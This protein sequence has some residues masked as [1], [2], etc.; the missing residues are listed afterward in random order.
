[1]L[2]IFALQYNV[3]E[4]NIKTPGL[5]KTIRMTTT[6][7]MIIIMIIIIIQFMIIDVPTQQS[8]D[9]SQKQHIT[10][11]AHHTNLNNKGRLTGHIWN[12]QSNKA[13]RMI[14]SLTAKQYIIKLTVTRL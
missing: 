14:K 9:Q 4:H 13:H 1:M 11:T 8:D 5:N 7:M 10:E 2:H 3:M 12:K 6:T